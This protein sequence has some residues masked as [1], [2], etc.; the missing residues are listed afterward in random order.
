MYYNGYIRLY[1]VTVATLF[2]LSPLLALPYI[3]LGI[4]R[5]ERSAYFFFALFLGFLA[6]LQVPLSDLFRHSLNI[7]HYLDKPFSYAYV[8]K[9]SADYFIPI[10][11]WILVNGNIPYQ[12]LRL[13]SVT[14][15]FFLLTVIFNYMIETSEREYTYGEVF[16]RFCIMYLFFEFIMTTSGVRYGFAVCQYI[17]ALHLVFNKKSWLPALFFALFCHTNSCIIRILHSY[18]CT[19]VLAVLHQ[20]EDNRIF[21]LAF[22]CVNSYNFTLQLLIGTARGLV[23]RGRQQRFRQFCYHYLWFYSYHWCQIVSPSFLSACISIFYPPLHTLHI[24]VAIPNHSCRW[25][26]MAAV[27]IGMAVMFITI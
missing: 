26:R 1:T 24:R 4:Y 18:K 25:T 19:A 17:Y 15:S 10:V 16:M 14:E 11:N 9:Q 21:R 6:W 13:F 2:L 20:T 23:F 7:Y 12:Y 5:Q 8:N 22:C 3:L 27:W